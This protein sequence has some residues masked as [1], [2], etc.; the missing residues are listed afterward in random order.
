[1]ATATESRPKPA[2]APPPP[3][4]PPEPAQPKEKNAYYGYLYES[5][6]TPTKTLDALLRAI[7]QYI[8]RRSLAPGPPAVPGP[9][10]IA[11]R[12]EDKAPAD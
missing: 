8:V 3:P 12:E 4:S 7:A 9:C 2:P 11:Q 5:N 6:K 1:M 10:W